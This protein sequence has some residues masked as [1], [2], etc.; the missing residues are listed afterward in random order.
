M[1]ASWTTSGVKATIIGGEGLSNTE[2][3][4]I[5]NE[6]AAGT[7]FTN[8]SDALKNPASA[9]AVA[10]VLQAKNI[11]PEAFTLNA[12]AAVEVLKAGIEK[13]G[14][15]ED[16]G[17]RRCGAKVAANLWRPRSAA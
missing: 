3:W 13:A 9:G 17:G 14:S 11:P 10:K 8:A 12:Y 5:G 15:A 6:A 4:A 7:L 1:P 16:A 2:Y